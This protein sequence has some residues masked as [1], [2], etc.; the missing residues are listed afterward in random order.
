MSGKDTLGFFH[1]VG[2]CLA[3]VCSNKDR[4]LP[5]AKITSEQTNTG[6][7]DSSPPH[8]DELSFEELIGDGEQKPTYVFDPA[9][10]ESLAPAEQPTR[11][12]T[13]CDA[14]DEAEPEAEHDDDVSSFGSEEID[15]WRPG[16]ETGDAIL[17][18]LQNMTDMELFLMHFPKT[19]AQEEETDSI[20]NLPSEEEVLPM[21]L[22]ECA[23]CRVNLPGTVDL[24][25]LEWRIRK[26]RRDYLDLN[27]SVCDLTHAN[28][29]LYEMFQ[30]NDDLAFA[31]EKIGMSPDIAR[32]DDQLGELFTQ[33][34]EHLD[35]MDELL[36]IIQECH[37][38]RETIDEAEA[39]AIAKAAKTAAAA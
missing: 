6:S 32:V 39:E 38:I 35:N 25:E 3:G 28:L 34:K 37:G 21:N 1:Q 11:D 30:G 16:N 9:S 27:D 4:D 19:C 13:D 24:I 14:E 17:D 12:K 36:D 10:R 5:D 22:E 20:F 7:P 29:D 15:S 8:A 18:E 26:A 33:S 31:L 2:E 23:A